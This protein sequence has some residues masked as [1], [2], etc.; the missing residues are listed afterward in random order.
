MPRKKKE[1]EVVET[2]EVE[3]PEVETPEVEG[4]KAV[5]KDTR[6]IEVRTYTADK[7]GSSFAELAESFVSNPKRAGYTVTV[8]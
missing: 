4:T 3:T 6:N 5:V 1:V 2:P 7:H 8:E